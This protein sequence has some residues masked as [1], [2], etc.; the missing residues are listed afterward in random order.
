MTAL[1]SLAP[2]VAACYLLATLKG[3]AV[4]LLFLAAS[5]AWC[6]WAVMRERRCAHLER[7]ARFAEYESAFDIDDQ[8]LNAA[9][10]LPVVPHPPAQLPDFLVVRNS[11]RAERSIMAHSRVAGPPQP[12]VQNSWRQSPGAEKVRA[13]PM[14]KLSR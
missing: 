10:P 1:L 12:E 11:A 3:H 6:A 14:H 5:L 2:V 8:D 13:F 4:L 9:P 7:L